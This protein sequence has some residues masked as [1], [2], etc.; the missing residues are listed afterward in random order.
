MPRLVS[1]TLL[2]LLAVPVGALVYFITFAILVETM[3][4]GSDEVALLTSGV[5]TFATIFAWWLL[6]WNGSVSW[7]PYRVRGTIVATLVSVFAGLVAGLS[8]GGLSG[9]EEVGMLI[10]TCLP[11]VSWLTAMCILWRDRGDELAAIGRNDADAREVACP[12]CGYAMTG[13]R[14]ARCPEC[15]QSYTLDALFAAQR[16]DDRMAD[17]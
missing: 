13:L 7:T 5:L 17:A 14:E 15:G 4:Y 9:Q 6:L 3:G 16:P 1:L 12:K 11:P 10:G 8:F 2:S